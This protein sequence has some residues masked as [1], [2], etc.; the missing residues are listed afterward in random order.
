MRLAQHVPHWGELRA[1]EMLMHPSEVGYLSVSLN[2]VLHRMA[3]G[4]HPEESTE[5]RIDRSMMLLES[6]K[7]ATM[8]GVLSS[9]FLS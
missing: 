6:C 5:S 4:G 9:L 3:E 2:T 1:V 7:W 8:A